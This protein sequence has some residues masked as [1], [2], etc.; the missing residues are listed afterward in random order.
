MRCEAEVSA[1][2]SRAAVARLRHAGVGRE[3]ESEGRH[4][5]WKLSEAKSQILKLGENCKTIEGHRFS[6][7][8]A[9][10]GDRGLA[11][12]HALRRT[13]HFGKIACLS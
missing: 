10:G 2:A 4:L 12:D 9:A 5:C 3:A 6:S 13:V 8:C 1:G 11:P 7:V